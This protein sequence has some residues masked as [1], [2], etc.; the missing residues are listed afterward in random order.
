MNFSLAKSGFGRSNSSAERMVDEME[1]PT[2]SQKQRGNRRQEGG[3]ESKRKG[4]KM[5]PKSWEQAW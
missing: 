4:K 2:H 3:V 5:L 1:K